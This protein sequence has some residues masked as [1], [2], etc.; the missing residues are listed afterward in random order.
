MITKGT[1]VPHRDYFKR[2]CSVRWFA[3]QAVCGDK[4]MLK[5]KGLSKHFFRIR[6]KVLDKATKQAEQP[7]ERQ[8]E[9]KA[10]L[11]PCVVLCKKDRRKHRFTWLT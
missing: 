5:K 1:A 11:I 7:K 10:E 6:S 9:P 8:G 4:K 3:F 2:V